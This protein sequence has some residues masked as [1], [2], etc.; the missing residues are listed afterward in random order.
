M[1]DEL[2]LDKKI[3]L[4]VPLVYAQ[5][6]PVDIHRLIHSGRK[7]HQRFLILTV[8]CSGNLDVL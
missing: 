4:K 6:V 7:A 1:A 5:T 3:R 2:F 8:C